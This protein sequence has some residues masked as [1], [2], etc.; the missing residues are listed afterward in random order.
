MTKNGCPRPDEAAIPSA[1]VAAL[2]GGLLARV[3]GRMPLAVSIAD[4]TGTIL[5]VNREFCRITGYEAAEAVGRNHGFLSNK[6]T[7]RRVYEEMWGTIVRGETWSGRLLN[8]RKDGTPYLADLTITPVPEGRPTHFVGAQRDVSAELAL[9]RH[10]ATQKALVENI[11]DT[12]PVAIALLN[13]QGRVMVDNTAYK[14]LMA[15]MGGREPA[16]ELLRAAE[17]GDPAG[18][19]AERRELAQREVALE[20]NRR[21]GTRWFSCAGLWIDTPRLEVDSFY[22]SE[23]TR[24]LLLVATDLTARMRAFQQ[25]KTSAIRAG[26]AELQQAHGMR[27]VVLG[28]IFQLQEPLN[29]LAAAAAMMERG[30]DVNPA[31]AR[32]L[33]EVRRAGRRT[34]ERLRDSVPQSPPEPVLPLNVNELLREVMDLCVERIQAEGI[35]LSWSPT[36]VL[37]P[38]TGRAGQLR[39]LFK[40]LLDNA[41]D[42]VGEPGVI[43][44]AVRLSTRRTAD[45]GIAV[46]I[47]DTGRGVSAPDRP[48][49]FEPFF[50]GWRRRRGRSGMGLAVAQN[51]LAE[52]GG[53]IDLDSTDTGCR[54]VVELPAEDG[55]LL[56]REDGR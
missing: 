17:G 27:E 30:G 13:E 15:D 42:A 49:I 34:I 35:G 43:D 26:T 31:L 8:R 46:E 32:A 54:V 40:I 20:V 14:V 51:I 36:P 24:A 41:I 47:A 11:I 16:W 6:K 19:L 1:D 25:A 23:G 44:R 45:G 10:L 53:T 18:F 9:E 28:A 37:P 52:H 5:Y 22:E 12:A 38:A 50:S 33:S 29:M 48:R 2:P 39:V 3:V 7:P 56:V 21:V 55:A 4:L